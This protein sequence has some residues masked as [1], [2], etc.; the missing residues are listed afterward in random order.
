M[1]PISGVIWDL[2]GTVLD[3]ESLIFQVAKEV[4]SRHGAEL[5][6][7]AAQAAT[8]LRP[9]ESWQ[10]VADRME[11]TVPAA[12]LLA[13]SEELLCDRWK[14]AKMLPGA[15]RLLR[16]LQ[17]TG[18]PLALATSSNRANLTKKLSGHA[19]VHAAFQTTCCGDE[20]ERGKPAP[21]CFLAAAEKLGLPPESC[22]A[23][24]DSRPGVQAALAAGMHV[25]VVPSAVGESA[26]GCFKGL[27]CPRLH[28]LPS[29]LAFKPETFGLAPF[30]DIIGSTIP[31]DPAWRIRGTVVKG[32][33][34]GSRELGIPTANL[35]DAS[36]KSSLAEAVTGIYAGFAS[37]GSSP[38]V[39]K[40]CMSIGFNPVFKNKQKTCE[41]WILHDFEGDFYGEEIRLVV[42]AY[43]RPEADFVS[44]EALVEQIH[45]DAAVTRAALDLE[46]FASLNEDPFL[47]PGVLP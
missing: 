44:I 25:V 43:I 2:D 14:E 3:T 33:G 32:F 34:R 1:S 6:E 22:L 19:H 39:H 41:P 29:L 18:V 35:D 47:L 36:L 24:E 23:I 15:L 13:E 4:V 37:I 46:P 11:L 27:H 16:H 8:G 38:A 42:C 31:V 26:A 10:V 20:V 40:T 21:D 30:G 12:Q 5:T 28:T 7:S 17:A 45:G 9:L